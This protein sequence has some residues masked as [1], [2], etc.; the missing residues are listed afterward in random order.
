MVDQLDN[1]SLHSIAIPV[2]YNIC[3]DYGQYP[4]SFSANELTGTEPAQKRI[5]QS[6]LPSLMTHL[7]EEGLVD[8]TPSFGCLCRLF[9]MFEENGRVSRC[10]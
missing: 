2:L 10:V 9:D 3:C 4:Q 8:S 6:R 5:F 7:L 1:S